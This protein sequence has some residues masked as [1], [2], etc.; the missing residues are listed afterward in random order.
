MLPAI[1]S[2]PP[3][4]VWLVLLGNPVALF[5][6]WTLFLRL[7][8]RM[9][10]RADAMARQPE[11]AA[12]TY[13]RAL[14][15]IYEANLVPVVLGAKRRTHPELYDRLVAAGVTPEYPRPEAPPGG[16]R[17]AGMLVL[18][19]GAVAGYYGMSWLVAALL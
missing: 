4:T 13:A 5:I 14:A 17:R 9:E 3:S 10:I 19:L 11:T 1:R 2:L 8:H 15:K 7:V 6:A 12:G 18:F 16:P